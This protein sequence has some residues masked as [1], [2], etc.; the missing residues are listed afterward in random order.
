MAVSADTRQRWAV[1]TGLRGLLM[2]LAG[3]FAV[4]FPGAALLAL[5]V[6]GGALLL[7]DGV[8]GLWSLTFGGAKT[9]NFWFDLVRNVLALVLGLLILIWPMV[10][11]LVAAT[12]LVYV[13]AFQAIIVGVMATLV[14]AIFIVYLFAFQAILVGIM[15]IAIIVRERQ[16]YA[17]IWPVLLS[18]VLYVLFGVLLLLVPWIGALTMVILGGVLAIIFGVALLAMAWRLWQASR[19][20]EAPAA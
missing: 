1:M 9:G 6:V 16:S 4:L 20:P 3:L 12:F 10:S 7:L 17:R 13:F 19:A 18:G 2:V 15:E 11:T 14:A 5:T 8:L